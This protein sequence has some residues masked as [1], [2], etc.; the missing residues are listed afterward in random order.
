[1]TSRSF[2]GSLPSFQKR[3]AIVSLMIDDRRRRAVVAIAER[4]AALD[5]NLEHLEISR[6]HR[7]PAA[8]AVIRAVV[9]R[10]TD[11]RE[12]QAEA[13]LQRDAARR[14]R[15][16][17][18]G[19]RVQAFDAVA[20][21][22]VRRRAVVA[23]RGPLS[24][25][26]IVRTLCVSKP[27]STS[28]SA[29]DVRISSADP[30]SRISASATSPTTSSDRAL[31]WRNARARRPA[32]FLQRGVEVGA[33]SLQRREQT[34]QDAGAERD[35]HRERQHAPV[36]RDGRSVF[37]ETRQV[38]GVDREQ[39]SNGDDAERPD[40]ARRRRATAPRFRSS[41]WR[42]MRPRLGADRGSNRDLALARGRAHQ[43]QVRDVR[44][45]DQQH[46]ADRADQ[47]QQRRAHVLDERFLKRRD[48]EASIRSERGR[49]LR[50]EFVRRRAAAAPSPGR[51]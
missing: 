12:R 3:L 39:R 24:D 2:I 5:R 35:D 14:A 36:E 20:H 4:A 7:E 17:D 40:R 34:E 1:M 18:A 43:Q 50:P 11:D 26:R 49:E 44:A 28:R 47:H 19:Q 21:Q 41:S 46:E 13:A 42:M 25:I 6:R 23:K 8:A 29:I 9:E 32:A 31:L 51:A 16:L 37:A 38:G 45:R 48:A 27:G 30:T 10:P 22:S 33:R 15:D